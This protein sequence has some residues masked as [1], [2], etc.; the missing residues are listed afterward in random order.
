MWSDKLGPKVCRAQNKL[1]VWVFYPLLY[2]MHISE[3]TKNTHIRFIQLSLLGLAPFF[4][5]EK[6]L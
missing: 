2:S 5:H 6:Q 4:T 3:I 1:F